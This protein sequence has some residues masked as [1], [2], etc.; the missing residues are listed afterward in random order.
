MIEPQYCYF[1][2]WISSAVLSATEC[3]RYIHLVCAPKNL[4]YLK[5]LRDICNPLG[6]IIRNN[7]KNFYTFK[8]EKTEQIDQYFTTRFPLFSDPTLQWAFI[9]GLFDSARVVF[10]KEKCYIDIYY[11]VI[12]T[13]VALGNFSQIPFIVSKLKY[14]IRFCGT[15][16]IDFLGKLYENKNL[17]KVEI[18][19]NQFLELLDCKTTIPKCQVLRVDDKAF[20]P[21][22]T[23]FSDAGYD[24][25]IIKPIKNLTQHTVL[26]DTGIK[27][28][29]Q[30]G[31]YVEIVPRSSLSKSGYMLANSIG[32]IDSNYNGNIF[33]ALTKIDLSSPNLTLPFRCCQ[34]I[35]RKQIFVD[36]EELTGSLDN[37]TRGEGGFGSSD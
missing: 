35:F 6:L 7:V 20:L 11:G 26:Y 10:N 28:R 13:L 36:I 37:T 29:P 12:D 1:L 31:Y 19:Y 2:G 32:I 30:A 24:L 8:V 4:E 5:L 27:I 34:M 23:K 15:N 25:T 17:L 16:C 22:K 9:R 14:K 3:T 18:K 33:I 21:S